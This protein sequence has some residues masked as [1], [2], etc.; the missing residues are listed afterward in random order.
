ML[1]Y[2]YYFFIFTAFFS[3]NLH[4]NPIA[5]LDGLPR[6]ITNDPY[7]VIN[8]SGKGIVAYKYK[9]NDGYYSE[10][11]PISTP[12]KFGANITINGVESTTA[13]ENLEEIIGSRRIP[14]R[15]AANINS[16]SFENVDSDTSV[17]L[18]VNHNTVK[19]LA[20]NYVVVAGH[21]IEN[22]GAEMN[23]PLSSGRSGLK[24]LEIIGAKIISYDPTLKTFSINVPV[25]GTEITFI[26]YVSE[27]S[28]SI[29]IDGIEE[30]SGVPTSIQIYNGVHVEIDTIDVEGGINKYTVE[31]NAVID[32]GYIL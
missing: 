30:Q 7:P 4:S 1:K 21:D 19:V 17:A 6:S 2:I 26:P 13:P 24:K 14:F 28:T 20:D 15:E 3:F 5:E 32:D 18:L 11:I 22:I 9:I 8:V 10:E 31:V 12:I 23:H 27:E 29:R 16:V 25:S